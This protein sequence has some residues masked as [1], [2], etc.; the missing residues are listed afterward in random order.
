MTKGYFWL[1]YGLLAWVSIHNQWW[2][3]F[4]VLVWT[5][6]FMLIIGFLKVGSEHEGI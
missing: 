5:F 2:M 4:G 3:L 6:L 1:V